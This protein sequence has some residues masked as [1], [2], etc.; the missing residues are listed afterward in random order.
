M[1]QRRNTLTFAI[2]VRCIEGKL[3]DA[4]ASKGNFS[5]IKSFIVIDIVNVIGGLTSLVSA[6]SWLVQM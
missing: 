1:A 4:G 5:I 6:G 3:Y 2:P